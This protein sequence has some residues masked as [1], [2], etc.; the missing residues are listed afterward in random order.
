MSEQRTVSMVERVAQRIMSKVPA[1]YGMTTTETLIYA[2]AAIEEMREPTEKMVFAAI[3]RPYRS[4]IDMW[5]NYESI[6]R[7]MIDAALAP[8]A[9]PLATAPD[10][11]GK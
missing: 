7:A 3:D 9:N 10:E 1:G 8:L 6:F 2:R 4:D 5:R 11:D